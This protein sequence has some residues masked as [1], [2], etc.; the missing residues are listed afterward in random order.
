M[1]CA[2]LSLRGEQGNSL[3]SA[4]PYIGGTPLVPLKGAEVQKKLCVL[5]HIQIA[6]IGIFPSCRLFTHLKRRKKIHPFNDTGTC[7]KA[8]ADLSI[9]FT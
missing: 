5:Q 3:Y 1:K 6:E 9:T 8:V 2:S 7:A 4:Q